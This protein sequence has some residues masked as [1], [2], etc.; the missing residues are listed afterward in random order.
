VVAVATVSAGAVE[1]GLIWLAAVVV[2]A[3]SAV[4]VVRAEVFLDLQPLQ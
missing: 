4:V 3:A 2:A 1:E